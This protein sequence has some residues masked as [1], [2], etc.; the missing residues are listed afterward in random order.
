MD[1]VAIGMFILFGYFAVR[2]H[3]WSFILGMIVFALDGLILLLAQDWISIAFH[4]FVLYCLF[5]G[6]QANRALKALGNP[7]AR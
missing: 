1:F 4:V 7:P 6:F 5:R 3:N 2:R